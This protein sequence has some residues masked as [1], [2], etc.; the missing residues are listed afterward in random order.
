M[1]IRR[2]E[3]TGRTS[4]SCRKVNSITRMNDKTSTS[5][6]FLSRRTSFPTLFSFF[7]LPW[8]VF[9]RYTRRSSFQDVNTLSRYIVET[10]DYYYCQKLSIHRYCYPRSPYDSDPTTNNSFTF[11]CGSDFL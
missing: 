7:F 4:R 9:R 3:Q 2:L 5:S 10:K 8:V 1:R 6:Q 11:S